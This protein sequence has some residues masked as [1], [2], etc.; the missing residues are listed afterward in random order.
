M[1]LNHLVIGVDGSPGSER[2]VRWAA[3][4]KPIHITL[5]HGFSPGIELLAAGFQINLDPVRAEHERELATTWAAPARDA[6]INVHPILVDDKPANALAHVATAVDADAIVIGLN[7]H[8]RR[9]AHHVGPV[10]H[11]LLHRCD[12]PLIVIGESTET[13]P[14]TGTIVVAL[15]RPTKLDN[16]E[17]VW[18]LNLAENTHAQLDLI[19][20]VEPFVYFNPE[21]EV[22]MTEIQS[23]IQAQMDDLVVILRSHHPTLTI[24]G[25]A[26]VGTLKDLARAAEEVD[27]AI[28][29]TGSHHPG[30]IESFLVGSVARW[31]PP[32]LH[33]PLAAIPTANGS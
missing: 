18:A 30:A 21:Y 22:D 6:G 29:V 1:S 25:E 33:C 15:S 10:T 27:A 8:G 19:S 2:A 9:S 26:R 4:Q 13:A 23:K 16:S 31:L 32:M 20:L 28:V 5:V 7:G 17:L 3:A 11:Q 24:S 12:V 14:L